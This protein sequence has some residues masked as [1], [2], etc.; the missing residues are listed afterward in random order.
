MQGDED[1]LG[2]FVVGRCRQRGAMGKLLDAA[3]AVVGHVVAADEEGLRLPRAPVVERLVVELH[4]LV[5]HIRAL[6][7]YVAVDDRTVGYLDVAVVAH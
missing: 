2:D 7:G 1:A 3:E 4:G 6:V 5:V